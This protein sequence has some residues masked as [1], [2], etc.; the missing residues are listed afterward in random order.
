MIMKKFQ[1]HELHNNNRF[2]VEDKNLHNHHH[3]MIDSQKYDTH[4]NTA[5]IKMFNDDKANNAL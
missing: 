5:F 4:E 1:Q 3:V 2:K